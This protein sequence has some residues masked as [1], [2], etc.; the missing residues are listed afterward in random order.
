M[1]EVAT[2][3]AVSNWES[4]SFELPSQEEYD[5]QGEGGLFADDYI[6]DG[7]YTFQVTDISPQLENSFNPGKDRRAF[8]LTV[9]AADD[10]ADVGKKTKLY[11]SV[12]NHS[13]SKLHPF[14]KAVLGGYIAPDYRPK[15]VDL[16]DGQF[17]ATVTHEKKKN[18]EGVM[19]DYQNVGMPF[20]VKSRVAWGG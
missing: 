2:Q 18:Q 20:A 9:V 8:T 12:S 1:P 4:V 19:T 13:K 17:K 16:R 11:A 15:L 6:Q 10:P 14:F 3:P 5:A 7:V